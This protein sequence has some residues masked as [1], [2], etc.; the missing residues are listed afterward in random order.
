MRAKDDSRVLFLALGA[1]LLLHAARSWAQSNPQDSPPPPPTPTVAATEISAD[2]GPCTVEFHVTDLAGNG[3][4]YARITTVIR[5]GFMN[6]R[7]LDLEAGTNADGRARFTNLPSQV[8]QPL[9]FQVQYQ[10]QSASYGIDPGTD[11]HAQRSVPLKVD[12]EKEKEK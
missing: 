11:C 5:Y 10:D 1:L 3:V 8:K 6:K 7:K 4:Y 2:M 9:Q 12:K